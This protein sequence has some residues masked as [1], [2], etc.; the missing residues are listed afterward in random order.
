MKR[1]VKSRLDLLAE[2]CQSHQP[3]RL[4][5]HNAESPSLDGAFLSCDERSITVELSDNHSI[6]EFTGLDPALRA[7]FGLRGRRYSF[8]AALLDARALPATARKRI[9]LKLSLPLVVCERSLRRHERM[10]APAS[11]PT[12]VWLRPVRGGQPVDASLRDLSLGGISVT[13]CEAH[14]PC[15]DMHSVIRAQI[16]PVDPTVACEVLVRAVHITNG[17]GSMRIGFQ[18]VGHDDGSEFDKRLKNLQDWIVDAQRRSDGPAP[19]RTTGD[20]RNA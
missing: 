7:H 13:L 4:D 3:V 20:A 15:I 9:G 5:A 16:V 2:A 6:P 1:R 18:F 12:T 8:R 10:T 11:P 14:R 17:P 19:R